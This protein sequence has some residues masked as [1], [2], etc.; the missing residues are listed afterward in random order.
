VDPTGG[1]LTQAEVDQD[2]IKLGKE[3]QTK[4]E[5]A[6]AELEPEILRWDPVQ[7][8]ATT[9]FYSSY[10]G[11]KDF[12][13]PADSIRILQHHLEF[14]QAL[15]LKSPQDAF[16][17]ELPPPDAVDKIRR[18]LSE[19]SR[20]YLLGRL[21]RLD[22]S[23]SESERHRMRVLG[24]VRGHTQTVRNW[25]YP[26]QIKHIVTAL[27]EPLDDE[28]ATEIGLQLRDLVTMWFQTSSLISS[29]F[30]SHVMGLAPIKGAK[31]IRDAVNIFWDVGQQVGK[32]EEMVSLLMDNGLDLERAKYFLLSYSDRL[33][34]GIYT[35]SLADFLSRYPS[36]IDE[37]ILRNVLANWSLHLGDIA[38]SETEHLFLA[39]PIWDRPLVRTDEGNYFLPL[40]SLFMSFPIELIE[41]LIRNAFPHL[42][43]R[44]ER[45]KAK[46][47][48]DEIER[49]FIKAFP[50]AR[51]YRGSLWQDENTGKWF[52]NDLL[53]LIDSFQIVVEAKSGRFSAPARRG[54]PCR[55]EKEL[56]E[57][58]IEP[59]LQAKRF[60]E[61]LERKRGAHKFTTRSGMTN[62]VDNSNCRATIRLNVTLDMLANVQARR[63]D[64]SLSGLIPADADLGVTLTLA[65]LDL[66]FDLLDTSCEKIHY[67][68]RR[69][70]FERNARY[71]ADEADLLALY[72]DNGFNIGEMEYRGVPFVIYGMSD[73]LA[74]YYI[75]KWAGK[76]HA[77]SRRP[78]TKW[79]KMMLDRMDKQLVAQWS[80]IGYMLLCLSYEEQVFFEKQFRQV[81]NNVS[82][83]KPKRNSGNAYA[84]LSGP[85]ARRN[86]IVGLAYKTI[87]T[88]KRD[89][90]LTEALLPT[91]RKEPINRALAVGVN[92]ERNISEA[93]PYGFLTCVFREALAEY[94]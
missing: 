1:H 14:L 65:D 78:Y 66:I 45:R 7:L 12:K 57:L 73:N 20:S 93:Y 72:V 16:T 51:S 33:I 71:L 79:W 84:L 88:E 61:Y 28:V 56:T 13:K 5:T 10:D 27:V 76:D 42:M 6:L 40:P 68:A 39:N 67:L 49:L 23:M 89:R 82:K 91:F 64:L 54:A 81:R 3:H 63:T 74:P 31:S 9:S 85:M 47:L 69:S 17:T 80:E 18:L 35:L 2:I 32:S 19:C 48:E 83:P 86:A 21:A 52:E 44:F 55:L 87:P 58:V 75:S 46:F 11:N 50:A 34:P 77:K 25:G 41:S 59:S 29:R 24:E 4:Y 90:M 8:L 15:I 37:S 60:S 53:V 36:Q 43:S 30:R 22:P 94:L 38:G 26:H 92:V 70:E 62:E